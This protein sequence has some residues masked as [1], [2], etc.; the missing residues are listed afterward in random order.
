M[1]FVLNAAL[2]Y[3]FHESMVSHG[4]ITYVFYTDFVTEYENEC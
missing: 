1:Y 3:L 2:A 4:I